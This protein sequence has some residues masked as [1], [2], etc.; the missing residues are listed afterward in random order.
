MQSVPSPFA[1]VEQMPADPILGLTEAFL[2]DPS[3]TRTNLGVGVYQN[4][5]GKV[6]VLRAVRAAEQR[7]FDRAEPRSY[8]PIDG[9]P[10]YTRLTQELVLGPASPAFTQGRAC[11]AQT[12]GGTGALRIGAD[13]LRR[14]APGAAVWMSDPSWENHAPLF[15]AAGMDVRLFPYFDGET[16]GL[17]FGGML[18]AIG[19]IPTGS[20]ILLQACCHNPTGVD[21][22]AEQWAQVAALTADRGI[23]PF[24]D[25][26]YQGFGGGPETDRACVEAFEAA[27]RPFVIASSYSKSFSIYRERVGALTV[28]CADPAEAKRVISLV[29]RVI[30]GI[31]SNPPGFGATIVAEVLGDAELRAMWL[32][33]LD[34]MR[35][36][37]LEMRG[38]LIQALARAGLS[39]DYSFMLKQQGMFSYLGVPAT[40]AQRMRTEHSVYFLDSSRVCVAALNERNVD[41]VARALAAVLT[42]A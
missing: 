26:A 35:R 12:P 15:A 8:L 11:T 24:V 9:L 21:L 22:T 41:H 31:Y 27:G 23:I 17:D 6:P 38:A 14:V 5:Q 34:G 19:G 28:V 30:R 29:K 7:L 3:P 33:E 13:F 40:V 36:R 16:R 2:K 25:F 1:Q 10:A 4:D 20:V 37:I 32:E 39:E 42:S 18:L